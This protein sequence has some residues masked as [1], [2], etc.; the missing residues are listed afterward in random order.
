MLYSYSGQFTFGHILPFGLGAFF[1]IILTNDYGFPLFLS[2]VI[3]AAIAS[4][5]SGSVGAS[6][7]RLKPGYQGLATFLFSQVLYNVMLFIFGEEGIS[8]SAS[9][10]PSPFI[11]YEIGV[12]LFLSSMFAIFL[13]EHSRLRSKLLA[14]RDDS[15]LAE[16]TGINVTYYKTVLFYVSTLFAGIAGC[17]FGLYISHA[18]YTIFSVT[19]TFLPIGMAVIGGLGSVAGSILGTGLVSLLSTILPISLSLSV[20]YLIYGLL[21]IVILRFSAGGIVGFTTSVAN[22]LRRLGSKKI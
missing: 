16:S 12:C 15:I 5:V 3:G 8:L 2:F 13:V 11:L 7:Q 6:T 19:N 14:I 1:T 9:V 18:D 4:A 10:S 17:F 20:S 22:R 21:L